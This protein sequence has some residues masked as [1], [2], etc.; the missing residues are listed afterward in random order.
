MLGR[1]AAAL[2][3]GVG[4]D[5]LLVARCVHYAAGS[6]DERLQLAVLGQFKRGKSTFIN[7]LLG[8]AV[9]P[10]GVIPLTA[11]RHVHRLGARAA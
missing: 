7:A 10:T 4:A 1:V 6:T 3:S 9:L 2:A 11:D 5:S 8:A